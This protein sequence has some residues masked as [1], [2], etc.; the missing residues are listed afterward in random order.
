MSH[1]IAP[2]HLRA[3]ILAYPPPSLLS[4][5]ALPSPSPPAAPYGGRSARS[6]RSCRRCTP[7]RAGARA[8]GG[9]GGAAASQPRKEGRDMCDG[10]SHARSKH[11]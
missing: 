8:N 6:A 4:A 7:Q 3:P 1:I 9:R 11:E 2:L 5:P 10:C